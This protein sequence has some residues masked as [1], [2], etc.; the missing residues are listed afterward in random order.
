MMLLLSHVA[1]LDGVTP[2]ILS[3]LVGFDFEYKLFDLDELSDFISEK[4]DTNYFDKYDKIIITDLSVSVSVADKI[5]DSVYKDKFKLFDHHA[6]AKYLNDYDFAYVCESIDSHKEC[7]TTLYYNYLIKKYNNDILKKKSVVTFVELVRQCDTWQFTDMKKE[8]LDLSSLHA[9]YGIDTFIENYTSFLKKNDV[10]HYTNFDNTI[11]KSLNRK[12]QEYIES[13]KDKVIIRKIR[14]Y[15]IGFV[16]AE[17]YRSELGHYICEKYMDKIDFACIINLN[18]HISFRGIKDIEI[19]K[20]AE[21]YG[22]GGH[23]KACAIPLPNG[24]KKLII[25]YIFGDANET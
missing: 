11:L 25:S 8:A 15:N 14:N 6:T 4:I 20:F 21:I 10:F 3:N 12:K 24:L 7:G 2:V 18:T 16:F 19:N 13:M 9:F 1:D 17:E 5:V 22:G 23:P